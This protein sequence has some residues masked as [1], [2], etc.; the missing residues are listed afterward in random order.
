VDITL[1]YVERGAGFPL[2]LLHGNGESHAV[3][4][5]QM[6]DFSARYRVLAVDT[7]GHGDSPRGG[8]P[9]T[10]SQFA[11]DLREFLLERGILRAHFLGFSD[12]GNIAAIFALRYPDMTASL[13][14]NGANIY[15]LGLRPD[16]Y[17]SVVAGCAAARLRA[18]FDPSA[19]KRAELLGLMAPQPH[20]RPRELHA[21][22]M[23]VLVLAGTRD[24]ILASHTRRIAR[25]IP[26]AKLLFLEG[27]HQL[28][29]AS[30]PAYNRA[31]LD[32]LASCGG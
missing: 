11:D 15:P 12:G 26:G 18:P 13:I 24:V 14:L 28:S 17:L 30:A 19:K 31:V 32:F 4:E 25:S 3:F 10:L 7:R 5:R 27:P 20:I 9:F 8:A 29:V 21:L 6:D 16:V 2:L 22:S 1:H 23:P